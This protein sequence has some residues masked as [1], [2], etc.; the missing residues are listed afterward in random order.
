MD[1]AVEPVVD[2][3]LT[4]PATGL[5]ERALRVAEMLTTPLLP[6]DYLDLLAPLHSRDQLRGRVVAV[7]PETPDSATLVIQPGR[8]WR[9]H[10]PGQYLR[11]GVDIDGVRY[12]RSYSITAAHLGPSGTGT[13]GCLT[14][15]PRAI[16]EGLVSNHLVHRLRP[17]AIIQLD[18]AQGEFVLPEQTPAK[19]LFVTAGIGITPVM[20]ILRA[21]AGAPAGLTPDVVLVHSSPTADDVVFAT[22]LRGLHADGRLHLIE[23]HTRQDGHL[24][25]AELDTLVPDWTEREAFACGPTGLVEAAEEHWASSG[26]GLR[27]HTELFRP[28]IAVVGEGGTVTFERSNVTVDADGA[29]ALLDAGEAAGVIMPSGCRMGICFSCVVPLTSGCV[30]DLR[31]GDVTTAAPGDG[32]LIQTCISAAAGTCDIDL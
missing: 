13:G 8:G 26:L 5:R 32:V 30:R 12:W 3:P 10:R 16:P 15:T 19:L 2:D 25:F 6:A 20:G 7:L 24:K 27:L 1:P 18:Q 4:V 23:R 31:T 21:H 17:G 11:V 14:I 9:E 29:T 28:T 22:E